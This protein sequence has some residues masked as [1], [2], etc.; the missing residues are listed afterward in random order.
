MPNPAVRVEGLDKLLRKLGKM[1]PSVFRPAIAEAAT[2]IKSKIAQYPR[3]RHGKQPFKTDKSR[4]YFF[5]ALRNS[6]IEVPYRRGLSPGS[7]ALGRRWTVEFRDD[8]KTAVIGNNA[9]YARLVQS[10]DEQTNYH[11]L[12]GWPTDKSVAE[13]EAHEVRE[14]I[15]RHISRALS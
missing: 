1:G 5:F 11:R 8:G 10:D 13:T 14:I 3:V 7:E 6:L 12:T 15:A 9:S 4:R 2:H